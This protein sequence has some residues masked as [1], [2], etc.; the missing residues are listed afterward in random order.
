MSRSP[1]SARLSCVGSPG[2]SRRIAADGL[3][4]TTRDLLQHEFG[5]TEVIGRGLFIWLGAAIDLEGT[6][7]MPVRTAHGVFTAH[8]YPYARRQSTFVIDASDATLEAAGLAPG[9]SVSVTLPP[10]A[11]HVVPR[12]AA[13]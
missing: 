11:V 1:H 4:S 10:E 12:P 7:F 5:V 8:A 13:S 3:S 9:T 6:V 2:V